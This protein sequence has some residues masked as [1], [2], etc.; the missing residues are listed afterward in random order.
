MADFDYNKK[1]GTDPYYNDWVDDSHKQ[2]NFL[3][4]THEDKKSYEKLNEERLRDALK[5]REDNVD[6]YIERSMND[7]FYVGGSGYTPVKPSV[8]NLTKIGRKAVNE[9]DVSPEYAAAEIF[10]NLYDLGFEESSIDF[11]ELT[12]FIYR[13]GS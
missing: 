5:V 13:A 9:F 4:I 8:Y 12:H 1:L 10:S 2:F 6:E 3:R 11:Y 7:M